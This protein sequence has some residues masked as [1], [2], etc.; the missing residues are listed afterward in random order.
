MLK[1]CLFTLIYAALYCFW[2]PIPGPTLLYDPQ[3]VL[4]WILPKQVYTSLNKHLQVLNH[5][6]KVVSLFSFF[7]PQVLLFSWSLSYNCRQNTADK[8]Y[9]SH[10][11]D[12]CQKRI[13]NELNT[14]LLINILVKVCR[15]KS[16]ISHMVCIFKAYGCA[17][18]YKVE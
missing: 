7:S 8:K 13:N 5:C 2:C 17:S 4:K 9:K 15:V 12:V 16:N 1:M 18:I 10:K 6:F 3:Y 14:G 11:L